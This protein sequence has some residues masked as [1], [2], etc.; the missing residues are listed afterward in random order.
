[1]PTR[2]KRGGFCTIAQD[3]DKWRSTD[4]ESQVSEAQYRALYESSFD[5]VLLTEPDGRIFAANP[6]AGRILG[7]TEEQLQTLTR[8]DLVMPQDPRLAALLAEREKTG[9]YQGELTMRRG[10]GT[11]F[12][13]EVASVIFATERGRITTM[14]I[15][16][17]SERKRTEAQLKQQAQ[18]LDIANEAIFAT[19]LDNSIT[20]WNQGAV[21]M[22]GW[23]AAEMIGQDIG[24]LLE[25]AGVSDPRAQVIRRELADWRGTLSCRHRNGTPQ[26]VAVSVTVLRDAHGEP[27]GRLTLGADITEQTRLQDKYERALRL[28]SIGMLAAGVAHDFNNILT[29]IGIGVSMLRER[30]S[31]RN[32][33]KLLEGILACVARGAAVTRQILGFAQGV[34]SEAR[35]S[36]LTPILR[37]VAD[38]VSETFPRAI[39]LDTDVPADLWPVMANPT[40]IHQVLLNL[41]VNARDAMPQGGRLRLG[42]RNCVLDEEAAACIEGARKGAWLVLFIED[43]GAGIAPELLP[44]IW[45][46]FFTT[47]PDETGTGLGLSTVRSI[48]EAHAGFIAVDSTAGDGTTFRVYLP[49][50]ASSTLQPESG[51]PR[52]VSGGG[53]ESILVVEDERGVREVIKTALTEAGY[54]VAAAA[55]GIE[56]LRMFEARPKQYDLVLTDIDMPMLNGAKLAL[57]VDEIRPD[58]AVLAMSGLSLKSDGVDPALFSGGFLPKPFTVDELYRAV[59]RAFELGSAKTPNHH[60]NLR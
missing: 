6:A 24:D 3:C 45:E 37:E 54:R 19:D 56:A 50:I 25:G 49:A 41:C 18:W 2:A 15:R 33:L 39:I 20:Y 60:T 58:L 57:A 8:L 43:T 23:T 9:R 44:R 42:G 29:P 59:R 48:V 22:T 10:D 1:M 35:A 11:A 36:Q 14:I 47:K 21:R 31:H 4:P 27:T 16:D 34:G 13:A 28:Q 30:L 46:P 38:I 52:A 32:D 53:G 5:G 17:E 51:A 55:N 26:V 40:Q 7:R 12:E